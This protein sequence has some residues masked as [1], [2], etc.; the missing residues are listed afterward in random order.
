MNYDDNHDINHHSTITFSL[1]LFHVL[2]QTFH[3][4]SDGKITTD[5]LFVA[6]QKNDGLSEE[7]AKEICLLLDFDQDGTLDLDELKQV[8][9]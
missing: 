8:S 1:F 5:E 3:F 9:K 2:I 6:L 4:S 7:K